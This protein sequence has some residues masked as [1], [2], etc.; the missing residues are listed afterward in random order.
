MPEVFLTVQQSPSWIDHTF[1]ET[2]ANPK[3]FRGRQWHLVLLATILLA[4]LTVRLL[5]ITWGLPYVYNTDEALLVN[6][7][8]AFGTGDLNPHFFNYPSLYIYVLFVIYGLSYVIGWI[9]GVFAST[10]DFIRLFFTDITLFYLPGRLI[11]VLTGVT[12]VGAVYWLGRRGYGVRV[13]LVASAFLT[14]S[15]LH[16][17]FSHY[18]KTHVPAG[19]LVIIALGLAWS[20]YL[21]RDEWQKYFLAGTVA[22]LA[23][24]I[25]YHAGFVLVSVMLAHVLRWR[26]SSNKAPKVRL[27]SGKLIAA[28]VGSLLGFLVG[29]PFAVL[30][31]STFANDLTSSAAVYYS[32]EAYHHDWAYPFT[33]LSTGMGVPL[34]FIALLGLGYALIRRRPI[35]LILFSQPVFLAAFFMLFATKESHH[36]LIAMPAV[37]LLGASLL[38]DV[39]TWC[40]RTQLLQPAVLV[41]TT[42]LLV[43]NSARASFESSWQMTRPDTRTIAK[44]WI[45]GNIQP[46]SKIVMDSGK[47]YL[48]AAGPPL[49][50][51]RWTVEQFIA[52]AESMKGESLAQRDGTRRIGYSGE[53]QYFRYQLQATDAQGGYDV[54]QILH[55]EGSVRPDVLTMEEYL[56]MGVKYAVVSKRAA[57]AP[58]SEIAR[59]WPEKAEKYWDFYESLRT[60]ATLLHEFIPSS[61]VPGPI[62]RIYRLPVQ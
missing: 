45:E 33:S 50:V 58:S 40:I 39:V 21:G 2:K 15:V 22:G 44:Q 13:G 54:V 42:I 16:V 24:S 27:F 37:C 49:R 48:S 23:A 6:H 52:R 35:D 29:T 47:Y 10:N 7:A 26:D 34:G 41:L 55:D 20:I 25:V 19:L 31:W 14:F 46:G 56:A 18:I 12:S 5:G 36:M 4:A 51:T 3:L 38:V 9:T 57:Y 32:G 61:T 28:V 8:M 1:D 59:H 62:I 30:D 43:F 11:A 60:R 53:A 17:T